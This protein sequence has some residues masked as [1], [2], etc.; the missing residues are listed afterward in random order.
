MKPDG[1]GSFAKDLTE[2]FARLNVLRPAAPGAGERE[3][4]T[5]NWSRERGEWLGG[6]PP[7]PKG[8]AAASR[9]ALCTF[10]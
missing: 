6:K 3:R 2:R 7:L 4:E 10:T 9:T 1:T 5:W 8:I